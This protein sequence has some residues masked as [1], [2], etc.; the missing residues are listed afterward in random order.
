MLERIFNFVLCLG[1]YGSIILVIE[2][3]KTLFNFPKIKDVWEDLTHD[4]FGI[5]K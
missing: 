3:R 4:F 5:E 2:H 1:F